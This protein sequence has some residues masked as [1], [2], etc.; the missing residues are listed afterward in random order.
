MKALIIDDHKLFLDGLAYLLSS[1]D[2][3][4]EIYTSSFAID[5]LQQVQE[6]EGLELILLDLT[7]PGL[8]G[9]SFLKSI[10]QENNSTPVVILS[11]LEDPVRIRDALNLG[12]S[13]FIPKSYSSEQMHA[14]LRKIISGN[15]FIPDEIHNSLIVDLDKQDEASRK[16]NMAALNIREKQIRILQYLNQ[17]LTVQEISK[18]LNVSPNT[19]K[20]HIKKIYNA[21]NVNSRVA[22]INEAKRLKLLD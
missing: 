7:M 19:I 2:E 20:T 8:D 1:F 14:A 6:I 13:G 12:A 10:R 16:L 11:S 4:M 22:A 3:D 17:G 9:V 18:R 21:L 15:I 5:A